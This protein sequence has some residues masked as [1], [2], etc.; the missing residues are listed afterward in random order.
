MA[1]YCRIFACALF[2]A[3]LHVVP[4]HAET[5]ELVCH[6]ND[7]N[8]YL[9]RFVSID[10]SASTVVSGYTSHGRDVY[11]AAPATITDDKV[12]WEEPVNHNI[13]YLLI[14]STGVLTSGGQ[15]AWKCTKTSSVF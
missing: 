5:V 7:E 4:S 6:I 14:R 3:A 8:S 13:K 15:L 12:M 10:M 2:V 11:K 9:D 1:L